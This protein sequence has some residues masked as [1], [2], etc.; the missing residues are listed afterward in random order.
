MEEIWKP[1][2]GYE[3]L[4]EVSNLGRVDQCARIIPQKGGTNRTERV[5]VK[6]HVDHYGYE[7]VSLTKDQR[8]TIIQVHRLVAKSFIEN[9]LSHPMINHKDENKLN[10]RVEN[11]EWCDN[12]YNVLYGTARQRRK[13][14]LQENWL[15]R[16][17]QAGT[18]T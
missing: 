8:Q 13:K 5:R 18:S 16:Q 17:M 7:R 1:V 4:Y 10:N 14:T 9:N 15:Q 2:V 6:S 11:L 12:R 3:G